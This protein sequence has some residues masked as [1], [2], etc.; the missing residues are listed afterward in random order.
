MPAADT[1]ALTAAQRDIWL[2]QMSSGDSPL[3]TIGGYLE[4]TGAMDPALMQQ[5]LQRLL[6]DHDALRTQLLRGAGVDG[7]PLQTFA[8]APV[9]SLRLDDFSGHTDPVSVAKAL[10]QA[11]MQQVLAMYDAPLYRFRMLRL[12]AQRHWLC[13]QVHHLILDGWGFGQM[14]KAL[15][16]IYSTLAAGD[17]PPACQSSYRQFV[18]E[19]EYYQRSARHARDRAYWLDK[20]Q[21]VPAPLL[22]ARYHYRRAGDLAASRTVVQPL[23]DTLHERMQQVAGRYQSSAFHVLLAVLHVYFSRTQQRD[24]WVVGLPLLN[25]SGARFKDTVGLFAQ[26]SAVRMGFGRD[27]TFADLVRAVRDELKR[28]FRHQRF[29]VSEL[30]RALGL[31][32]EER[33]QLFEVSVSYEPEDHDFR[34]GTALAHTVKVSNGYENTPLAIHLLTNRYTGNAR[35]YMVYHRAWFDAPQVEALGARLLHL[36]E[37]VLENPECAIGGFDLLTPADARQLRQWNTTVTPPG[38]EPLIHRRI[39]QVARVA[40]HSVAALADGQALSYA[41][42]NRRANA[43]AHPLIALGV[44]ADDRIAVV[45]RRGLDTLVGL[46]AVLK[47][48]AAYVPV[49]PA[50]PRERLDYLLVD[51]APAAVLTHSSLVGRLP[52]V[53]VPVIELDRPA[54]DGAAQGNPQL[55]ALTPQHLAYVIYTSGSTGLPKGVMVEHRMLA[56]LVDWHCAAFDLRQGRHA[57][58]LAGFGFDAMAWEVWPTLC[59][60]ATLHLAPV[61]EGNEDIEALL[62]WWRAQPLDVSFLPTPVAEFAFSQGQDHPTLQTLLIGGDRLR[63]FARNQR[64]AVINNYGPTETTV[65]ATSGQVEAGAALHIGRPIANTRLHVLD[66]QMQPVPPGVTGELYIAGAGVARGYLNRPQLTAERFVQDPFSADPQA[67]LYRSGDLVRWNAQG[68]LDYLGR[69]DDQVKIR[70]V[71]I[72]LGEIEAA[73]ACHPGVKEA[74]V[75]VRDERL[76]AWF[77]E[78]FAVDPEALRQSLRERLPAYMVPLAYTRLNALPLTR[79]GKLDRRALPA[80]EPGALLGCLHEP[81][82]GAVEIGMAALWA[83]VLEVER[84]GRHDNFFELG[85]HSLLAVKLVERLRQAGLNVDV[86]V[87]LGQP[88]VAALAASVGQGQAVEVPPNRVPPG[89]LQITPSMLSLTQLDQA[90]IDCIVAS[91]PGGV[92]NVQEIYPLATLQQG[93]LYHHLSAAQGDPYLLQWRLAFDSPQRLHTWADA[94]QVL[95]DR[96]DI[97]RTAFVWEG[98][99]NPQQVVLRTVTMAVQ[100][101]YFDAPAEAAD[102]PLIERL[103][104]RFDARHHRMDLAQAPLMRLVYAV[105]PGTEQVVAL[106]LFHHLILDNTAMEV[107]CRELHSVLF[108]QPA[109]LQ[110]PVPYRN[111]VAEVHLRDDEARHSR[112]FTQMLGSLDEPTLPFGLQDVH[113]EGRGIEEARAALDHD[114]AQRLREQAR[115]AGVSA[116]SLMHL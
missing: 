15:S 48:G 101:V 39:E 102:A 23:P 20:Y 67:R 103:Q 26:V 97:L 28:D 64:Y 110:P 25:R 58:S 53:Q 115:Q 8:P 96:H 63:Q 90:A 46:L 30:N 106:L 56:N 74:V 18:S 116:A 42:L 84:V 66:E 36:L 6:A 47:S 35:L 19:D 114:L 29:P 89:C 109:D 71:R 111:Y 52:E 9:L 5:A 85:G 61:Q 62:R 76:L 98:L 4:L 83:E 69:N 1:F 75:L 57:S 88:T 91:V 59:A 82:Q 108:D 107:V 51:S 55:P 41:E 21:S 81:A 104:Q 68:N 10:V 94:L 16:E 112:F 38:A 3:Y 80:P 70:G 54:R 77:T 99:E 13:V 12:G 50:H 79:N 44:R 37:Q 45:A 24:D 32:R 40:P 92:A 95:V 7:L 78:A 33:A 22:V 72:E 113:S 93:I 31:M 11:D 100:Q 60:G 105:E 86:H 2:D 65:V 17:V 14:L 43:L 87:L 73:L 27:C 34:Y 49:D